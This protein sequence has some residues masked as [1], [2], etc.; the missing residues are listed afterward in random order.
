MEWI[1]ALGV[2]ALALVVFWRIKK[3][4]EKESRHPELSFKVP[5]K[6]EPTGDLDLYALGQ[7]SR[8]DGF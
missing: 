6:V 7:R 2:L 5:F 1:P 3:H 4:R 8:K